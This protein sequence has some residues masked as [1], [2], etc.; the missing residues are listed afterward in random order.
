MIAGVTWIA[1]VVTGTQTAAKGSSVENVSQ[2]RPWV[3]GID[4][5]GTFTDIVALDLVAG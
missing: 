1:L 4:V 5:G 2:D 3:V